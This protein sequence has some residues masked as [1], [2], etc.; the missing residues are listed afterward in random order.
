[1]AFCKTTGAFADNTEHDK[2]MRGNSGP[3]GV[4]ADAYRSRAVA[5]F[6][7]SSVDVIVLKAFFFSLSECCKI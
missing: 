6:R 5:A 2:A 7:Q 3:L 4:V 1:V